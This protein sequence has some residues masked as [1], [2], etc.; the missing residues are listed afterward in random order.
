MKKVVVVGSGAGG[1]SIAKELQGYCQVTVLEEGGGFRPFSYSL[2]ALEK[3]RKMGLFFDERAIP[4]LFPNMKIRKTREGMVLVRGSGL[5]GSTTICAGNGLRLDHDLRALGIDLDPEFEEIARE[6][7][8]TTQHQKNWRPATRRLFEI[9][10]GMG[11]NPR[12]LP[13]MGDYGRCVNCGRCILG[14]PQGAKWDSR[15][16]L[17]EAEEKGARII[18]SCRVER[19]S[20]NGSRVT[21]VSA[22]KGLRRISISADLVILAAGGFGT[23][24]ILK[25][26]GIACDPK[27]FVDP[28][29]CVAAEWEGALQN[30]EVCMPFVVEAGPT[31]ISPYFDP[32]S[33]FFNKDW[34][35]PA[36]N[37]LSLMIKLADSNEGDIGNGK[38]R[39]DLTD[40]DRRHLSRGADLCAEILMRFGADQARFFF[41]TLNAGHPGGMLPLTAAEAE[42]LHPPRLPD[43]LYLADATLFPASLG[44]PP[45]LTIIALAKRVGKR[46]L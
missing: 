10:E 26:S 27:L 12:P 38:I 36:R 29:L 25:N 37:I 31:I 32:L 13:K 39:K 23:P 19:V 2:R 44:K 42:S 11:F 20:M 46:I 3:L 18:T 8:V 21:G 4:L 22:R 5:G 6:I 30:R 35:L 43:N 1:A 41:G 28:V 45:I 15:K 24:V 16:Y 7:P 33:F 14:C 17:R 40:E 9:C 34:R